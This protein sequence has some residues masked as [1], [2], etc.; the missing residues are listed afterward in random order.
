MCGHSGERRMK[1]W[2]L[3]HKGEKTPAYFLV[4][5]YE[6]ESNTTQHSSFMDKTGM[7]ILV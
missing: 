3:D 6:H 7:N 1:V 2:F 5:G 4:D